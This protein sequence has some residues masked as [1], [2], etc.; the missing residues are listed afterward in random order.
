MDFFFNL[1]LI[2]IIVL[3]GW[4][5]FKSLIKVIIVSVIAYALF[6]IGFVWSGQE[7]MDNLKLNSVLHPDVSTQMTEGLDDFA[8]RRKADSIIDTQLISDY[9]NTQLS[10]LDSLEDEAWVQ[11]LTEELKQVDIETAYQA[12]D[13]LREELLAKGIHPDDIK[14]ELDEAQ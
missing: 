8:E 14:S 9:I 7:T 5:V 6:H 4:K 3:I 13:G 1:L 12:V 2:F 10:D 11:S